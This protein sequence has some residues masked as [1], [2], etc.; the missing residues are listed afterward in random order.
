MKLLVV[1]LLIAAV[2]QVSSRPPQQPDDRLPESGLSDAVEEAVDDVD[3]EV[4]ASAPEWSYSGDT[5]P[6]FWP[7]L[8]PDCGGQAQSPIDIPLIKVKKSVAKPLKFHGYDKPLLA[9]LEKTDHN[10]DLKLKD[11][12]VAPS[13]S[14]GYLN[15]DEYEFV[16]L[17]LHWG[18]NDKVGSEHW[19]MGHEFPGEIHFVHYNKK[20]GSIGEAVTEA[21]G[22]LVLGFFLE[23]DR[24]SYHGMQRIANGMRQLK[25]GNT[26]TL[27][28]LVLNSIV[29]GPINPVNY[30]F[31]KGSLTT[32]PC[33]ESVSWHVFL[34]SIRISQRDLSFI[35]TARDL[36]GN[37][38]SGNDRPV[39]PINGRQVLVKGYAAPRHHNK[40]PNHH[41]WPIHR[42][43]HP[44]RLYNDVQHQQ[45]YFL[46]PLYYRPG[47][48]YG[49][50][51][52]MIVLW[53]RNAISYLGKK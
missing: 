32:P 17:H 43:Q 20:Y 11:N 34:D 15:G 2:L 46:P 4:D 45:M 40:V 37:L 25:W 36:K 3:G 50:A 6:L 19:L 48:L 39:L 27:G 5:G 29:G 16:Q 7:S 10:V 49:P 31:Y 21:D 1:W 38:I 41:H 12:Q 52:E 35:R 30:V 53:K 44:H 18:R 33:S 42:D 24:E 26:T 51:Y 47:P 23:I 9:F 28:P 22:L 14:G 13:V 8:Y